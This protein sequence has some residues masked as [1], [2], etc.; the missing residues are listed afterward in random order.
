LAQQRRLIS[1]LA[2]RG[3]QATGGREDR[4]AF[5]VI[6]HARATDV[7]QALRA[8]GIVVDARGRHLRFCPDCLTTDDELI[9][10]AEAAAPLLR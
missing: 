3:V 6:E 1:L 7:A 5:V 2:T 4:G 9:R 8:R 10:A